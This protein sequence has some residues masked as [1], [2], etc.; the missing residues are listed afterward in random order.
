M[1]HRTYPKTRAT[2]IRMVSAGLSLAAMT[3]L[4]VLPGA[5]FCAWL[6]WLPRAQFIPAVMAG[7]TIVIIAIAVSVVLCGRLYCSVVCPLG[8]AQ[9]LARRL[10]GKLKIGNVKISSSVRY[11][12]LALFVVGMFFG[13]TG[14]IAPY[15]IFGRFLSVGVMRFGEPPI[16]MIVWAIALFLFILVMTLFRARWWCNQVCPVG[17]FLGLFSRFALFRVRIDGKKCVGCGLCSK[18][19]EKGAIVKDG[20]KVKIDHSK[21]VACFNCRSVCKKELLHWSPRGS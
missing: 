8:I 3:L 18:A 6:G 5:E 9:D 19:C 1:L 4:F 21:C 13:F 11:L 14:F 10:F 16:S 12:I 2:V 7:E 20:A 15:G 17:A